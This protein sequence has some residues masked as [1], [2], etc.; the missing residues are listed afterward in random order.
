MQPETKFKMQVQAR[1]KTL[2]G[3]WYFKVNQRALRG[4][5]DIIGCY[6]GNF[7]ALELKVGKNKVDPLQSHVIDLIRDSG[8]FAAVVYPHNIDEVLQE[9][10]CLYD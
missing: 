5:P 9:L 1:L 4:I 6:R 10:V 8:G 7:F 3:C 2:P